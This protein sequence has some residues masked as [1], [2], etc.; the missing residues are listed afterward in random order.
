MTKGVF[1]DL[2]DSFLLAALSDKGIKIIEE[3]NLDISKYA[4]SLSKVFLA[5]EF[6]NLL[7][8]GE[9]ENKTM[10]IKK[11]YLAGY[12]T[13]VLS[14]LVSE[15]NT[16]KIDGLTLMGLMIK[17][18]CNSSA[19]IIAKYYLQAHKVQYKNAVDFWASKS[20]KINSPAVNKRNYFSLKDLL[21]IFRKVYTTKGDYWNFLR[22]KLKT[23]RNIYRLFDQ[24]EIEIL[25]SKSGT[26]KIK[27]EYFVND[28]GVFNLGKRTYLI[29][30]MVTDKSISKAV[31]R[32]RKIGQYLI[33]NLL[34]E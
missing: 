26:A 33:T 34:K 10:Y 9:V 19:H 16:I 21:I 8:L 29:G 11:S 23:S 30:T 31:I 6:I 5:A 15:N 18:S 3:K 20:N 22:V 7:E 4:A 25:G 2:N 27:D 32:I 12:G 13:D 24:K 14:D 28:F 17:Y 1:V